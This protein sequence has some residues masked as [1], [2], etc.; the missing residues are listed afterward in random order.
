MRSSRPR[1]ELARGLDAPVLIGHYTGPTNAIDHNQYIRQGFAYQANYTAG[2]P[3]LDIAGIAAGNLTE[4]VYFDLYPLNNNP[5]F[6]GAW[7][8]YPFFGSGN[9]IVSSISAANLGG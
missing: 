7:N 6:S 4:A 9:V 1:D 2:L 3:I 8:N 5:V